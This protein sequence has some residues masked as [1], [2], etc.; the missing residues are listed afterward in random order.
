LLQLGDITATYR[1]GAADVP[2]LEGLSM[3]LQRGEVASLVGASGTGKSTLLGVIAGLIRPRHGTML[4]DGQNLT[5]LDESGWGRFR[6]TRIG[7][8][9]QSGNLIPFLTAAENIELA[10]QFAGGDSRAGRSTALLDELSLADRRDHRPRQLSG[11]EAQRVA[12]AMAL[13][14]EPDLLLA[15]EVTGELDSV[16]AEAVMQIIFDIARAR[17]M[18]VLY[19]THSSELATRAESR[20]RLVDGK[21]TPT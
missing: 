1:D 3:S 2:V 5:T 11:G 17:G 13:V 10:A 19:V 18:T 4:F 14:N 9:M 20:L 15:D 21:V 12:V 7:Y 16:N 8:V 6:A